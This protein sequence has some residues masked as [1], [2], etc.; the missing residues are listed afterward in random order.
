MKPTDVN[1]SL[2][3]C[4]DPAENRTKQL[5]RQE[6][7]CSFVNSRDR[8]A[9]K[10]ELYP[11]SRVGN[12]GSEVFYLDLFVSGISFPERFI[13][14]FQTRD[15]SDDE[16]QGARYAQMAKLCSTILKYNHHKEDLGLVVYDLAATSDHTEFR[17]FF[18]DSRNSDDSCEDALRSIFQLIGKNPNEESGPKPLVEDY[19]WYLNRKTEP[20]QRVKSLASG[21][22]S[23]SPFSD[24]ASSVL[25]YYNKLESKGTWV[26]HP[27]L[28][29]GDLHARNLML[30]Q[31]FPARCELIDFGWVH[32]GHPAKDFVLMEA[33]L[34]YMLLPEFLPIIRSSPKDDLFPS[35]ATINE[36]ENYLWS[37][38]LD[39][40]C[41]ESFRSDFIIFRNLPSHQ[42]CAMLRVYRC[43]RV[44]RASAHS[45]L[46]DYCR[47]FSTS[48][49]NEVV[50]YF[51]GA[52][53]MTL[54]QLGFR[55]VDQ[56]WALIGLNALGT[57][58]SALNDNC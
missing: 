20:I 26:V 41:H 19:A 48:D 24:L 52:F 8:K 14:K 56:F 33:T 5:L 7:V 25:H 22:D 18:L 2:R 38:G 58:F 12:S 23:V 27:Y 51:S 39:L 1:F 9:Y 53:L 57:N 50:H 3:L 17:G 28:V 30:S 4:P 10:A 6:L 15:H 32:F 36:F 42:I 45:V 47:K 11:V 29:H 34:K 37:H 43:I 21:L 44:I 16:E 13:A 40:P 55:D 49:M 46:R 54:S 31:S 35:A